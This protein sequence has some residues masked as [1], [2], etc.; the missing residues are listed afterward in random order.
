MEENKNELPSEPLSGEVRRPWVK[1]ALECLALNEALCMTGGMVG[2]CMT[3][4]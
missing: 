3:G 2:D 4:S 1:P